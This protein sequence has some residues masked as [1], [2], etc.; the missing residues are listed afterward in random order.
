MILFFI[1]YLNMLP[2]IY[3]SLFLQYVFIYFSNVR[4][5]PKYKINISNYLLIIHHG[6]SLKTGNLYF[7]TGP[8]TRY[9][10]R[11]RHDS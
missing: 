10:Q 11:Q 7:H 8:L 2:K 6:A 9:L 1:G 4:I 5:Y 3:Q